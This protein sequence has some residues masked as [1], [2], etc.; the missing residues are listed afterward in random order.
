[1]LTAQYAP[2][3]MAKVDLWRLVEESITF[4]K[5][6]LDLFSIDS[7]KWLYSLLFQEGATII[8]QFFISDSDLSSL[9]QINTFN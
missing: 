4:Y 6:S 9:S 5:F 7:P 3:H 1:M 8:W 2:I